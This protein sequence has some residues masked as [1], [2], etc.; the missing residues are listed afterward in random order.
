MD[1]G[2]LAHER[3]GARGAL[4]G[5]LLGKRLRFTETVREV[6]VAQ[7]HEHPRSG[8]TA[9]QRIPFFFREICLGCHLTLLFDLAIALALGGTGY[10]GTYIR[11]SEWVSV[12]RSSPPRRWC[13]SSS[14]GPSLSTST[15]RAATI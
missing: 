7:R 1:A 3:A 6:A 2:Q 4:C 13:S 14:P 10:P 15:T 12:L 9:L 11:E 5:Q 8:H